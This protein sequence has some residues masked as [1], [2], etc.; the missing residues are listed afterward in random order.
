MLSTVLE[1]GLTK[2]Q[3]GDRPNDGSVSPST[4]CVYCLVQIHMYDV[5]N[6]EMY[7]VSVDRECLVINIIICAP[8]VKHFSTNTRVSMASSLCPP[9]AT[10]RFLSCPLVCGTSLL[11]HVTTACPPLHFALL[12]PIC[13]VS[14]PYFLF[15]FL[16]FSCHFGHYNRFTFTFSL[17][18]RLVCCLGISAMGRSDL[19]SGLLSF[20]QT[21]REHTIH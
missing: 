10:E 7:T 6:Y 9:S 11:L 1:N 2:R 14:C 15:P 13:S 3:W 12:N 20:S 8:V 18:R 16:L 21:P 19:S 5:I 17:S 4:P